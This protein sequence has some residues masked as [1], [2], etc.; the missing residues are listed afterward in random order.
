MMFRNALAGCSLANGAQCYSVLQLAIYLRQVEQQTRHGSGSLARSGEC[1]AIS[2]CSA[3][4]SSAED[5]VGSVL[6]SLEVEV[7]AGQRGS[8]R[9]VP[10]AAV[11]VG[12]GVE[13]GL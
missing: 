8:A 4:A 7:E 9:A 3:E 6:K 2:Q 5:G 10:L 1:R 11:A 12:T 13:R